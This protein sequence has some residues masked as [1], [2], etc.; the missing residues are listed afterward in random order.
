[1]DNFLVNLF[2]LGLTITATAV[3]LGITTAIALKIHAAKLNKK[4]NS[5]YGKLV[6]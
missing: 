2:Y 3:F 4:L 1:M 5:E 6:R